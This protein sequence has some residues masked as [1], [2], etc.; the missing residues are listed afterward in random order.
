MLQKH[1]S[2]WKIGMATWCSGHLLAFP[3]ATAAAIFLPPLLQVTSVPL[4]EI[5]P[6]MYMEKKK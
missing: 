5:N 6:Q 3:E 2:P 1:T 4:E